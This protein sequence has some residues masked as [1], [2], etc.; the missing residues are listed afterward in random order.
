MKKIKLD[1]IR[2]EFDMPNNVHYQ[3]KGVVDN[4]QKAKDELLESYRMDEEDNEDISDR[5]GATLTI[6]PNPLITSIQQGISSGSQV[7]VFT[8]VSSHVP[9]KKRPFIRAH[10]EMHVLKRLNQQALG[11]FF[12]RYG[13]DYTRITDDAELFCDVGAICGMKERNTETIPFHGNTAFAIFEL[14][15]LKPGFVRE[16]STGSEYL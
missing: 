11:D 2:F 12:Q 10:E 5:S 3:H 16:F 9:E 7:D 14:K 1:Q 4:N 13:I 8:F 15:R 6:I